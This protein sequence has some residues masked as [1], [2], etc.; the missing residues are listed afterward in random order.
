M[1]PF[2]GRSGCE[3]MNS[4]SA[5]CWEQRILKELVTAC[6]QQIA[7]GEMRPETPAGPEQAEPIGCNKFAKHVE[8]ALTKMRSQSAL[9]KAASSIIS[10]SPAPPSMF[11]DYTHGYA[12]T[13]RAHGIPTGSPPG[14]PPPSRAPEANDASSRKSHASSTRRSDRS[15]KSRSS[16]KSSKP[17]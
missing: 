7:L 8:P 17:A 14:T 12:I 5:Y 11:S 2:A 16:K 9:A 6:G 13:G 15:A 3:L 1:K 4:T 10:H